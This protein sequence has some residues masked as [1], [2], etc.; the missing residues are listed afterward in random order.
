MPTKV[1]I[2]DLDGGIPLEVVRRVMDR[3]DRGN[4]DMVDVYAGTGTAAGRA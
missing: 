1:A 2:T 3:L 4:E